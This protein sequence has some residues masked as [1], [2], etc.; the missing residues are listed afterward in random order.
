MATVSFTFDVDELPSLDLDAFK[1]A[2]LKFQQSMQGSSTEIAAPV[3]VKIGE[4]EEAYG[5]R[6]ADDLSVAQ[7]TE[8]FSGLRSDMTKKVLR[9]IVRNGGKFRFK[10]LVQSLNVNMDD[11]SGVWGGLTKRTRTVLAD[12][13]AKLIAWQLFYDPN[14]EWEDSGG[15]IVRGDVCVL[16]PSSRNLVKP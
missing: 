10:A 16:P 15:E 5:E 4:T 2:I 12:K 13:K 9:A 7:A 1:G 8:F 11:L 6:G 14:G 3:S